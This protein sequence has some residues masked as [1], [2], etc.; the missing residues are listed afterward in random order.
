[1]IGTSWKYQLRPA[2]FRG[3][4]F[5]VEN[6]GGAGGRRGPDHEYPGRDVPFAEDLGR[7]Q[8]VFSFSGYLIGDDYPQR[9]DQLASA[10]DQK[11]PGELIHPTYG[12]VDVV[13]R[14]YSHTETRE[15][16]R[17]VTFSFTFHEAGQLQEPQDATSEN[18]AVT[19]AALPVGVTAIANFLSLFSTARGGAW[20]TSAARNDILLLAYTMEQLRLPAPTTPQGELSRALDYLARNAEP[21][22]AN[23]PELT[24]RV[25]DAF[26][27][28]TDAG[29]ALP[30]VTAM[31]RF[32]GMAHD[33][34]AHNPD[35][36]VSVHRQTNA[37]AFDALVHR[38][39][40]REIGYAVT[41]VDID[42]YDDAIA[43]HGEIIDAFARVEEG[44]ANA[45]AD[46]AFIAL[47]TLRTTIT[48]MILRRATALNPLV[49]YRL[50]SDHPPNAL[51]L[52]W[53][54]YQDTGRDLEI[55]ARVKARN[56]AFLPSSGRVLAQ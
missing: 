44:A 7:K 34:S 52:A 47:V 4:P 15:D 48:R 8:R 38:F 28:F 1:M 14:D 20:I 41:G 12:A 2:S 19:S 23:P 36:P 6:Y 32:I 21:L 26:E 30:V 29:E 42:N 46:N 51:A 50:I 10:C 22:A 13:C 3:V 9:R 27:A 24:V 40:C 11:G 45:G 16:G 18:T 17:R 49:T 55:V 37:V 56:P 39:A 35:L 33:P 53:R 43:F 5:H 31:L 54:L 25:D